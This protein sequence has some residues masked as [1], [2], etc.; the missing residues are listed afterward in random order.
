MEGMNMDMPD[1]IDDAFARFEQLAAKL[2][3]VLKATEDEQ[4]AGRSGYNLYLQAQKLAEE[5]NHFGQE[6]TRRI[7]EARAR[8]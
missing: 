4:A 1:N 6:L 5:V 7:N 2:D 3:D 8:L